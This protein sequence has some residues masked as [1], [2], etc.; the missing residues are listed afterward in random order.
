[1]N[2]KA[3]QLGAAVAA[4]MAKYSKEALEISKEVVDEVTQEANLA[5]LKSEGLSQI[6]GKKYKKSFYVKVEYD[7]PSGKREVIANKEYQLTH[8]LEHGHAK[9][10]GGRTRA[11]PHFADAQAVADTLPERLKDALRKAG[12]Q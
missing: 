4:E 5:I 9:V 2:V 8:L 6:G 7:G 10:N 1:M 12:K 3:D 11:F